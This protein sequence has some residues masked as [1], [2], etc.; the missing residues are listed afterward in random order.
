MA[1]IARCRGELVVGP[2]AARLPLRDQG[3]DPLGCNTG[4]PFRGAAWCGGPEG[5]DVIEVIDGEAGR[6][7]LAARDVGLPV[8]RGDAAPLRPRSGAHRPRRRGPVLGRA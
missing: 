8:V 4:C 2:G 6:R 7:A 5:M 3:A 1:T